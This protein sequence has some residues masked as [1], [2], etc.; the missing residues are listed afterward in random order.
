MHDIPILSVV[1]FYIF[2]MFI[3]QII[4]QFIF[5]GDAV[6][7]SYHMFTYTGL[8]ILCGVIIVCTCIII[9][10]LNEVKDAIDNKKQI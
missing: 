5:V 1:L 8:M 10:K 7:I 6:T 2:N 3:M 4:G 9:K